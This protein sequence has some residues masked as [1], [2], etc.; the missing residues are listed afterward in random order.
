M[1]RSQNQK[2]KILL[3]DRM[4]RETDEDHV[5]TMQ[6][7]ISELAKYDICAERKSIYDDFDAL[8][9]FGMDVRYRKGRNGG[10]Y[11]AG[12]QVDNQIDISDFDENAERKTMKLQFNREKEK[13]VQSFFGKLENIKEKSEDILSGCVEYACDPKFF[14]WLTSMGKDVKILKPKK[15]GQSYRE[16][17]KTIAKTYK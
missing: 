6:E 16:Y 5:I 3:L 13:E 15:L 11:L 2:I 12:N 9:M 17:L 4:I 8:R 7:I 10:Y 1:A 14:G